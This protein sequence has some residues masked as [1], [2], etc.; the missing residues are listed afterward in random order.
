MAKMLVA[1]D[2]SVTI[3][4]TVVCLQTLQGLKED[5]ATSHALAGTS[6]LD[7]EDVA[8]IKAGNQT[9][10]DNAVE[11][12]IDSQVNQTLVEAGI[13]DAAAKADAIANANSTSDVTDA[14]TIG[15]HTSNVDQQKAVAKHLDESGECRVGFSPRDSSTWIFGDQAM[16]CKDMLWDFTPFIM[17]YMGLVLVLFSWWQVASQRR[18]RRTLHL[19]TSASEQDATLTELALELHWAGFQMVENLAGYMLGI[20]FSTGTRRPCVQQTSAYCLESCK[21]CAICS[22][23][24]DLWRLR[25]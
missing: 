23:W 21:T 5:A 11:E 24:E 2:I 19:A 8:Q 6:E 10:I 9:A 16:K 25:S 18:L 15:D 22:G 4:T 3:D 1:N 17:I 20:S 14:A 13:D 12:T 7:S